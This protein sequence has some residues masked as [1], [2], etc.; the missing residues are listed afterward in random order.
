MAFQYLIPQAL[1][2]ELKGCMIVMGMNHD[3]LE[4]I[5]NSRSLLKDK[6]HKITNHKI[7]RAFPPF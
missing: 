3:E 6:E 7:A 5:Y 1:P 4:I 2:L